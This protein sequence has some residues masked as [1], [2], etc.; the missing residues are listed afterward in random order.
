MHGLLTEAVFSLRASLYFRYMLSRPSMHKYIIYL[1]L[2]IIF[3]SLHHS[4]NHLAGHYINTKPYLNNIFVNEYLVHCP[5][6]GRCSITVT[7]HELMALFPSLDISLP[8]TAMCHWQW[9]K[10]LWVCESRKSF[11][12]MLLF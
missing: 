4:P 10:T 3:L 8:G 6:Y 9:L 7:E 11:T 2:D 12:C 5:A 1:A